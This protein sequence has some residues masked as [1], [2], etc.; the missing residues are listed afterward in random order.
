MQAGVPVVAFAT[1]GNLPNG[2][3]N[4]GHCIQVCTLVE[5]VGHD[6]IA[7]QFAS[8]IELA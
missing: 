3:A 2:A 8:V 1:L 7:P 6:R 5:I 4:R